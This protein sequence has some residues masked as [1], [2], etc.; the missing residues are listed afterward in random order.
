MWNTGNSPQTP[1]IAMNRLRVAVMMLIVAGLAAGCSTF[2]RGGPDEVVVT[3]ETAAGNIDIAVSPERAPLSAGDFLRYV[4]AKLYDGAWF[5][6]TVR[7]DNDH[8]SPNIEVIQGGLIDDPRKL[9]PIAHETTR[10]T[11]IQH[12]DGTVSIARDAV[13]T[14]TAAAFFICIGKQPALDFGGLR[15]RDGQG[16]AAFGHV[17][18]GMDV[19]RKIQAMPATG[20]SDT[21]YTAGQMISKPVV[22]QRAYRKNTRA[23][24]EGDRPGLRN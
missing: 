15:N 22:I 14:G 23:V 24:A 7:P 4:D 9:P 21:A 12:V 19:V 3:L 13:G 18:R 1:G 16:F 11:G 8:G 6:R 20:P 10:D 5:Y 2:A 17:V